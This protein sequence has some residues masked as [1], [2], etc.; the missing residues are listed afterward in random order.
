MEERSFNDD[1]YDYGEYYLCINKQDYI[2][3]YWCES[4]LDGSDFSSGGYD[5]IN[6]MEIFLR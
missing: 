4:M 6:L 1:D 5:D 2:E 3:Y